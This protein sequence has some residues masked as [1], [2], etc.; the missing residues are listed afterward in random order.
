M[1]RHVN[2]NIKINNEENIKLYGEVG[3]GGADQNRLLEHSIWIKGLSYVDQENG[4]LEYLEAPYQWVSCNWNYRQK[5][6][7]NLQPVIHCTVLNVNT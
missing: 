4:R 2:F 3:G 5:H 7:S 1:S 6:N